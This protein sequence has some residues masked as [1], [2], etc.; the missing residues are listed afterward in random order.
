VLTTKESLSTAEQCLNQK[1]CMEVMLDAGVIPI[2]NEND[3]TSITELMFTDNDELSG[4]MSRMMSADLLV[5][6]SNIDGIYTGDPADPA[7][8]LIRE[9]APG[10]DED[11]SQYIQTSRS[12]FGRGGMLTKC[13]IAREV[14][15]DGIEVV[16]ANG[17][18]EGILTDLVLRREESGVPFTRFIPNRDYET[19][20]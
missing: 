9:I 14:A 1:N 3:T 20:I 5:I 7:S 19:G 18:R 6:L 11:L 15:A 13:R 4:L 12:S 17:K 8:E 10:K 16:I 2:V